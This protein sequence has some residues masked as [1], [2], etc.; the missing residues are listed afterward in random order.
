MLLLHV[1][2]LPRLDEIDDLVRACRP[3]LDRTAVIAPVANRW[4]HATP[5][6]SPSPPSRSGRARARNSPTP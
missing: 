1:Y 5:P 6:R 3:V 2:A 4:L